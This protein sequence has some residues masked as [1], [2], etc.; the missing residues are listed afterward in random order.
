MSMR[1]ASPVAVSVVFPAP[2]TAPCIKR[3]PPRAVTFKSPVTVDAPRFTPPLAAKLVVRVFVNWNTPLPATLLPESVSVTSLTP[4]P[5]TFTL[6]APKLSAA[7]CTR[8]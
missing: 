1:L 3:L 6:R 2:L 4:V 8:L 5:M 7:D